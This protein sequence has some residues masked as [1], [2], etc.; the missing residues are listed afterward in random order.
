MSKKV[1]LIKIIDTSDSMSSMIAEVKS[2]LKKD[3]E[4]ALDEQKTGEVDYT[5]RL[6]GFASTVRVISDGPLDEKSL[7]DVDKLAASGMTAMHDAIGS[8][9][10]EVD[11]G[12]DGVYVDIFTDGHENASRNYSGDAVKAMVEHRI[13][14]NW[15]FK[16][17]GAN[18]DAVLVGGHLGLKMTDCTSYNVRDIGV[19]MSTSTVSRSS[20]V[21]SLD[22]TVYDQT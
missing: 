12:F 21:A 9:I 8:S 2:S 20:Y 13:S 1:L 11:A 15:Q 6:V 3:L 17:F 14:Q 16:Y 5:L 7:S 19:F 4:V 22:K 18:Q 10:A